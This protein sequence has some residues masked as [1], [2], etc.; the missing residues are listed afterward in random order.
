MKQTV[1]T[2]N[3][4]T[5]TVEIPY[6]KLQSRNPN[7]TVPN[8]TEPHVVLMPQSN[9]HTRQPCCCNANSQQ[10]SN[11]NAM[12][13]IQELEV[14]YREDMRTSNLKVSGLER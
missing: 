8:T 2:E 5:A 14:A 4:V 9:C 10:N 12:A 11:K 1:Q 3:N 6:E 7:Y 13:M